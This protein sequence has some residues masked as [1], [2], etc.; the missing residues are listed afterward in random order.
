[1]KYGRKSGEDN[2]QLKGYQ[3]FLLDVMTIQLQRMMRENNEELYRRI[4]QIENQMNNNEDDHN[5]DR[6]RQDRR[7]K[8]G[9]EDEHIEDKIEGVKVQIPSFKVKSD[10]E[11][12]LKWEMKIEQLFACHNYTKEMKLKV[13]TMEFTNYALIWRDQL[14]KERARYGD[15]LVNTWEKM[16]RL[17][18]RRFVPSHFH[19]DLH[20]KL[21]RLIQGSKTVDEYHKEIEVALIRAN[22]NEEREATMARFLH[23][24]NSD[25]GDVMELQN[26]VELKELVH[27]TIKVEQ[28]LKRKCT[29]K[30]GSSNFY[31]TG[32]KDKSKKE[33][34]TSSNASATTPQRTQNK[35]NEA[36]KKTRSSDI[37]CFKC[38]R[39]GH[40]ASECPTKRNMLVKDGEIISES[41]S[42]FAAESEEEYNEKFVVGGDLFMVR[43]LLGNL[44]KENDRSQRENIFHTRCLIQDKVCSLII[45]GG[46]CTNVASSRLVSKLNLETKPHPRPYKLQWLSED[47]EIGVNKQVKI[48]FSIRNYHDSVLC[49]VVSME[50]SHVLLERLGNLTK[51]LIMMDALTSIIL[52]IMSGK[53]HLYLCLP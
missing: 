50:A 30:R 26:Y 16:K 11:A 37:K 41:S 29:M 17:M 3:R 25:I 49:D 24:L 42:E 45:D 43:R 13:A 23:G 35:S 5:G 19:R 18:R 22:I 48:Y 14:Q 15:P 34:A 6:R 31:Q 21:Q 51:G 8:R 28:Q 53:L 4:E 38:L 39:R 10:L 32:W 52:C 12:Y 7:R 47:G 40:I 2:P 9:L 1:L 44:S 36:P 20:N 46:S 33:I 27:Q